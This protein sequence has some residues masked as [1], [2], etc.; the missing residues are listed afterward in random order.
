MSSTRREALFQELRTAQGGLDWCHNHTLSVDDAVK[1][2]FNEAVRGFSHPVVSLIAV[3]GYGR[4]ELA[5]YSDIDLCLVPMDESAP[6]I[7]DLVKRIHSLL[8]ERVA[9]I[10]GLEIGYAYRLISD[11]PGL[12]VTSR[13]ALLDARLVAGAQQ[14]FDELRQALQETMQTGEFLLAKFQERE[15]AWRR[16]NDT[17]L[18]VE[19]DL[20]EGAGGLRSYHCACWI[21]DAIGEPR[22]SAPDGYGLIHRVRNA[23]HLLTGRKADVLTRQRQ[24]EL[25]DLWSADL[26]PLM[27]Q[28]SE[29]LLSLDRCLE[30]AKASVTQNTFTISMGVVANGGIASF[31]PGTALGEAARGAALATALGIELKP[32]AELHGEVDGPAAM[33]AL[34]AGEPTIRAMDRAE[35]LCELLPELTR[36]RTLFPRDSAHQFTV[37]EHSLRMVRCLDQAYRHPFFGSLMES[38]PTKESLYLATLLHDVGKWVPGSP[39]SESGDRI[40]RDVSSRW[41]LSSGVEDT[42]AWLVRHH[43]DLAA[44]VRLRDVANPQT[45]QNLADLVRTPERLTCLT[46]LTWADISSVSAG[47]WTQG[48]EALTIELYRRTMALLES[49]ASIPHDPLVHRRRLLRSLDDA[50]EEVQEFAASMPADYIVSTPPDVVR[51]H[52]SFAKQALSGQPIVEV[53]DRADLNATEIT[54]ACLDR[55]YLLSDILG[56]MYA[57]DLSLSAI[58]ASTGKVAL[59]VFTVAFGGKPLPQA[60]RKTTAAQI[61]AVA[62]GSPGASDAI[63]RDRGKDPTRRQRFFSYRLLPGI[64]AILEVHA[65]RGRGMAYRISKLIAQHGWNITAARVGQWAGRGAAAFYIV[66]VDGAEVTKPQVDQALSHLPM[67]D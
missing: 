13:T 29:A 51:L 44:L 62:A 28:I 30:R 64:P 27:S 1:E 54:V 65:P 12:D 53:F 24:S 49:E 36:C 58:R 39:H 17:P 63:L 35:I 14:P 43:L 2:T 26:Y 67:I 25:A 7:D 47:A 11:A 18:V 16:S 5:P 34:A 56:V 10:T 59:D 33:Q 60:T 37:F 61:A 46:L 48:Q 22:P 15:A 19:P 41:S 21:A 57:Y 3:G 40:A 38:L 32:V 31:E 8:H 20:K 9:S 50:E 42:V 23:L 52:A 55:P 45:A 6:G 66:G 4:S